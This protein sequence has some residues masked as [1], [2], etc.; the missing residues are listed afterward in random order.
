MFTMPGTPSTGVEEARMHAGGAKP[1]T[2]PYDRSRIH[3]G[4][5]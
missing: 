3:S 2:Q 5:R 1:G 4:G